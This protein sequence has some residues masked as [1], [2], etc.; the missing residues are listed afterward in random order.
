VANVPNEDEQVGPGERVPSLDSCLA[1]YYFKRFFNTIPLVYYFLDKH[2]RKAKWT[3]IVTYF[4]LGEAKVAKEPFK[5]CMV[6]VKP[7]YAFHL[8][9]KISPSIYL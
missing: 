9:S 8:K 1:V 2:F 6:T 7:K 3:G 5:G 4:F